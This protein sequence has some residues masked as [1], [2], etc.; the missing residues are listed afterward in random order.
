[1]PAGLGSGEVWRTIP[2]TSLFASVLVDSE[3]EWDRCS[4]SRRIDVFNMDGTT[5]AGG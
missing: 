2:A 3:R 1:M 4:L 5:S